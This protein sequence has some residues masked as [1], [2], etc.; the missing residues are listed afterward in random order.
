MNDTLMM[1][2]L[3]KLCWEE[4]WVGMRAVG[5]ERRYVKRC[6]VVRGAERGQG[7][8][9]GKRAFSLTKNTSI[10]SENYF[11]SI[12]ISTNFCIILYYKQV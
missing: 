12:Y 5:H 7:V 8:L 4:C 2:F 6:L 1:F 9:I 11:L 10:L 3:R